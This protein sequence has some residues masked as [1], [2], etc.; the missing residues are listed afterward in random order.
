MVSQRGQV[1]DGQQVQDND[2]GGADSN[3]GI[4]LSGAFLVDRRAVCVLLGREFERPNL[5]IVKDRG[6]ERLVVTNQCSARTVGRDRNRIDTSVV[7]KRTR[8]PSKH[9]QCASTS[10]WGQG[11]P[12]SRCRAG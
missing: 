3:R 12:E 4:S 2:H 1:R 8:P 10:K 7:C 11:G 6:G 5:L 9:L